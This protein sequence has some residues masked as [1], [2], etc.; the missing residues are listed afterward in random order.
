[1]I[2]RFE[3]FENIG[4]MSYL[5]VLKLT[6]ERF[7]ASQSKAEELLKEC[8]DCR[9]YR[10]KLVEGANLLVL[11]PE[12]LEGKLEDLENQERDNVLG[13]TEAFKYLAEQ[14][15]KGGGTFGLSVLLTDMGSKIGD[16]NNLEEFISS[17][18]E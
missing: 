16:M 4:E 1:M 2:E 9:G 7:R 6:A 14:A 12:R 8:R 13:V 3:E 17:L 15:I 10:D 11:L 5:D 18:E